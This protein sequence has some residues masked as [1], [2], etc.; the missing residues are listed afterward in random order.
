MKDKMQNVTATWDIELN[1]SCPKCDQCFDLLC[2]PDFSDGWKNLE[3]CENGT[4]RSKG[5][6][7]VCPKCRHEF[8]VDCEY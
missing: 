8:T 2:Y 3:V 7:V 4:D 6:E 5:I 1:C